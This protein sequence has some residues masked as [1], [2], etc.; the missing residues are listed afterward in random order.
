MAGGIVATRLNSEVIAR[1][2]ISAETVATI[3][4]EVVDIDTLRFKHR[5]Y[6][7]HHN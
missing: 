7:C 2:V 3:D 4:R 5:H 6:Y 1:S